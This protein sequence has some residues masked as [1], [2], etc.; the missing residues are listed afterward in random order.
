MSKLQ[1]TI[2][3]AYTDNVSV[4][5]FRDGKEIYYNIVS[6]YALEGYVEWLE[7]EGYERAYDVDIYKQKLE[8]AKEIEEEEAH[9]AYLNAFSHPL[10]K[11][12]R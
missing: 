8:E 4:R 6:L 3:E 7:N 12:D 9:K 5:K 1:Y 2:E 10:M 11:T